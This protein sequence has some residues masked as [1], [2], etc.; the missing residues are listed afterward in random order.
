MQHR[1]SIT[2]ALGCILMTFTSIGQALPETLKQHPAQYLVREDTVG[3]ESYDDN[4]TRNQQGKNAQLLEGFSRTLQPELLEQQLE[5]L[6][7]EVEVPGLSF[8]LINNARI[9]Y[10]FNGGV[11]NV[12]SG[13]PVNQQT[14]FDAA[15]MSKT[16]F[17]AFVLKMVDEGMLSLD[18]PLF[19]YMPYPDIAHDERYKKITARMAL[20]HTT[21]FP[22]WRFLT[23]DGKYVPDKPLTIAFEPGTQYQYSGEGFQYLA[24]VLAH[25]HETDL[26]GLQQIINKTL[27]SPLKM[28]SSSFIWTNYLQQHRADGHVQGKINAGWSIT[29]QN[30]NFNAAASLQTNA[31]FY[32]RFLIGIFEDNYLSHKSYQAM[33][34]VQSE[35]LTDKGKSIYK[36]GLGLYIENL[37][38]HTFYQHGGFN[39][40]ASGLFRYSKEHNVG[41]VFFTNSEKKNIIDKKIMTW[42]NNHANRDQSVKAGAL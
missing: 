20:S 30:P 40:S 25:L 34:S 35:K 32:A 9:V 7:A 38:G 14:M 36:Y 11:R 3:L 1:H 41:Y 6:V 24:K 18:T 4:S 37:D 12:D 42:L 17:S 39:G 16:V 26:D 27:L 23:D 29:A 15:S 10:E 28:E 21:G 31:R 19:E 5:S 33:T 22:N 13:K 8:A 2:T